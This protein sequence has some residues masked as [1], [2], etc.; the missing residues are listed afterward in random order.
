MGYKEGMVKMGNYERWDEI[1]NSLPQEVLDYISTMTILCLTQALCNATKW[2]EH[3]SWNAND[4]CKNVPFPR[5]AVA[6]DY[7]SPI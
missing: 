7:L 4:K 1:G 2:Y 5:S 6:Q 3:I